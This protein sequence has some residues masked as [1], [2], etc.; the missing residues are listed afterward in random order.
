MPEDLDHLCS[1]DL[2]IFTSFIGC[3]KVTGL[4]KVACTSVNCDGVLTL[5][6]TGV[7]SDWAEKIS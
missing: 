6:N 2:G 3:R 5:R 4:G 1:T 7:E